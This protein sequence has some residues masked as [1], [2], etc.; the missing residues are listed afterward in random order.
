M[1]W[2]HFEEI[3]LFSHNVK[4]QCWLLSFTSRGLFFTIFEVLEPEAVK[5]VT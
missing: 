3:D 5:D 2:Y 1:S 4:R